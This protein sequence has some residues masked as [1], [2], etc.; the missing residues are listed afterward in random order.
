MRIDDNEELSKL[1]HPIH[2]PL[3][4]ID[5]HSIDGLLFIATGS[6][7]RNNLRRDPPLHFLENMIPSPSRRQ[8]SDY[9]TSIDPAPSSYNYPQL[10]P[11]PPR[12]QR[13][14]DGGKPNTYS[15]GNDFTSHITGFDPEPRSPRIIFGMKPRTFCVV[16]T[17]MC[18]VVVA[19]AV[20]GAVGGR[21][22]R[23]EG[24]SNRG[25]GSDS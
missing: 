9:L 12:N 22:L 18:L 25:S 19:C 21:N 3:I 23:F 10:K 15:N 13:P 20:G 5:S 11:H 1:S 4:L 7:K 14:S 17:V 6:A 24:G 16:A 2:P 8:H